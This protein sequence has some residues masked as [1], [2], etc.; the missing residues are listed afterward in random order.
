MNFHSN[1]N[2]NVIRASVLKAQRKFF[3]RVSGTSKM[4]STSKSTKSTANKK[5]CKLKLLVVKILS[6]P[7]STEDNS[8][9]L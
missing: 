1:N 5:Y 3:L 4:S 7:D 9:I 2:V 8:I 6:K